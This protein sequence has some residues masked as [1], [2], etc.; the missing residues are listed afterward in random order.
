MRLF[1]TCLRITWKKGQ[2][3]CSH[4]INYNIPQKLN[5]YK[6]KTLLREIIMTELSNFF[7][8]LPEGEWCLTITSRNEPT[9]RALYT[10]L[11]YTTFSLKL[12]P[13]ERF[14]F[15]DKNIAHFE[16]TSCSCIY[17]KTAVLSS[18]HPPGKKNAR[19]LIFQITFAA[20]HL[21]NFVKVKGCHKK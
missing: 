5:N 11:L 6:T 12:K 16:H 18:S 10:C 8:R 20:L 13:N 19:K 14:N 21:R 2:C 9:S 1:G 3:I 15:S 4:G 7:L 17:K